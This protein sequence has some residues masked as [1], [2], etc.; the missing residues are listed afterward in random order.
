M[1]SK[2]PFSAHFDRNKPIQSKYGNSQQSRA[3]LEDFWLN[4]YGDFC[5]Y[6]MEVDFKKNLKKEENPTSPKSNSSPKAKQI[7][8]IAEDRYH[9]LLNPSQR[10]KSPIKDVHDEETAHQNDIN[11]ERWPE[12][13]LKKLKPQDI[14]KKQGR[15]LVQSEKTFEPIRDEKQEP[16]DDE[17]KAMLDI[18][19]RLIKLISSG[20]NNAHVRSNISSS[21]LMPGRTQRPSSAN[22]AFIPYGIES[23]LSP[24]TRRSL[25]FE[26]KWDPTLPPVI[27]ECSSSVVDGYESL[28]LP[29][30]AM[31]SA[32]D[33]DNSFP[34]PNA[35]TN[36]SE[37]RFSERKASKSVRDNMIAPYGVEKNQ[38]FTKSKAGKDKHL[39]FIFISY[40]C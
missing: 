23:G 18:Q 8:A 5:P 2:R 34:F 16:T 1:N 38:S 11:I 9:R 30:L 4:H 29:Y 33:T 32:R 14:N 37:N 12:T 3:N 31:R 21:H 40:L 15:Q 7:K 20:N 22:T 39:M 24:A 26:A 27:A 6:Y 17:L 35:I 25:P 13:F 10:K 36:I 28:T 19:A